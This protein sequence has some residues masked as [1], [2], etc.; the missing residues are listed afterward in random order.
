MKVG[1]FAKGAVLIF[2]CILAVAISCI[3]IVAI[4]QKEGVL[5]GLC[6]V[7]LACIVVMFN[8]W[9]DRVGTFEFKPKYHHVGESTEMPC[10]DK[11]ESPNA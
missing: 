11:W 2:I 7:S 5:I 3:L 10:G 4:A 1:N 8:S 6:I 9:V